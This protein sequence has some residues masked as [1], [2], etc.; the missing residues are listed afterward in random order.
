MLRKIKKTRAKKLKLRK[1]VR[2]PRRPTSSKS[3]FIKTSR[4]IA[5]RSLVAARPIAAGEPLSLD[6]LTAKRPADG[7]SPMEVWPMLGRPAARAY[8]ADEA[9]EA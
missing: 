3:K 9:V 1:I 2:R 8:Q 6:N 4:A 5:R 7:V